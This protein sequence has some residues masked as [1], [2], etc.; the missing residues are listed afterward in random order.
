[1]SREP[2]GGAQSR[3][4]GIR[5]WTR[6]GLSPPGA[7]LLLLGKILLL[8][9]AKPSKTVGVRIVLFLGKFRKLCPER[10]PALSLYFSLGRRVCIQGPRWSALRELTFLSRPLLGPQN[11]PV[12][13]SSPPPRLCLGSESLLCAPPRT[14]PVHEDPMFCLLFR[15]LQPLT[16]AERP[17]FCIYARWTHAPSGNF[18]VSLLIPL[19]RSPRLL[20]GLGFFSPSPVP[21]PSWLPLPIPDLPAKGLT[22]MATLSLRRGEVCGV[23]A[24]AG[25]L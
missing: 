9:F 24:E 20:H 7:P 8:C 25:P 16:H 6:N 3:D 21:V 2:D 19:S 15:P 12:A 4:T 5:T 1:M 11:R 14:A 10:R 18:V 22:P 13:L 23:P 17:L